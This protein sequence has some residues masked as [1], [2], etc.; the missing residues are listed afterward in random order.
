VSHRLPK[1]KFSAKFLILITLLCG[2]SASVLA[3]PELNISINNSEGWEKLESENLD[4]EDNL[5]LSENSSELFLESNNFDDSF[6]FVDSSNDSV[7]L[8][9]ES[10]VLKY[11]TKS[12]SVE[13]NYSEIDNVTGFD[14][15]NGRIF[16]V[17]ASG[18][19]SIINFESSLQNEFNLSS[20]EAS[21]VTGTGFNTVIVGF[22]AGNISKIGLDGGGRWNYSLSSGSPTDIDYFRNHTL[23]GTSEGELLKLNLDGDLSWIEQKNA[24]NINSISAGSRGVL[25]ASNKSVIKTNFTDGSEIWEYEGTGN[26]TGVDYST[27][28]TVAVSDSGGAVSINNSKGNEISSLEY[29]QGSTAVAVEDRTVFVAG[30]NG[31]Y[32]LNRRPTYFSKGSIEYGVESPSTVKWHGITAESNLDNQDIDIRLEDSNGTENSFD[33]TENFENSLNFSSQQ[34]NINISFTGNGIET[35]ALKSINLEGVA[36]DGL[37]NLTPEGNSSQ[38]PQANFSLSASSPLIENGSKAT[39]RSQEGVIQQQDNVS[40]NR[41]QVQW[42]YP[43]RGLNE[44]L[45][46]LNSPTLGAKSATRC[47]TVGNDTAI[48]CGE[49]WKEENNSISGVKVDDNSVILSNKSLDNGQTYYRNKGK[50]QKTLGIGKKVEWE[51]LTI[52]SDLNSG[53]V[54][55]N[56]SYFENLRFQPEV[57]QSFS[58][59]GGTETFDLNENYSYAEIALNLRT[60]SPLESPRIKDLFIKHGSAS[61]VEVSQKEVAPD[62]K[63][64]FRNKVFG[65][66]NPRFDIEFGD[67]DNSERRKVSHRYPNEVSK[68]SYSVNISNSIESLNKTAEVETTALNLK[69]EGRAQNPYVIE[70]CN[71]L[72]KIRLAPRKIYELDKDITC[73]GDTIKPIGHKFGSK[74][75]FDGRISGLGSYSIADIFLNASRGQNIGLFR[76]WNSSSSIDGLTIDT[77][78]KGAESNYELERAGGFAGKSAKDIE[79]D[80][81]QVKSNVNSNSEISVSSGLLF[82]YSDELKISNSEL[83]GNVTGGSPSGGITGNSSHLQVYSSNIDVDLENNAESRIGNM[84][85][86]FAGGL[87]GLSDHIKIQDVVVNGTVAGGDYIGGF[88]GFVGDDGSSSDNATFVGTLDAEG[89][90]YAGGGFGSISNTAVSDF[91]FRGEIESTYRGELYQPQNYYPTSMDEN[92]THLFVGTDS[93]C[94]EPEISKLRLFDSDLNIVDSLNISKD[95]VVR[96]VRKSEEGVFLVNGWGKKGNVTYVKTIDGELEEIWEYSNSE[97]GVH[98]V[99]PTG[100][101]VYAAAGNATFYNKDGR[102]TI[103]KLDNSNGEV[104]EFS[105]GD[106]WKIDSFRGMP[107]GVESDPAG[108][109]YV[110]TSVGHLIKFD[111]ADGSVIWNKSYSNKRISMVKFERGDLYSA[112]GG[113]PRMKEPIL[114]KSDKLTGEKLKDPSGDNW[115]YNAS[116]MV[117]DVEIVDGV[118]YTAEGGYHIE[119]YQV[120]KID[121]ENGED[122]SKFT[123]LESN[124]VGVASLNG[125]I[126]TASAFVEVREVIFGKSRLLGGLAGNIENSNISDLELTG[127]LE[128]EKNVGGVAGVSNNITVKNSIVNGHLAAERFTGSFVANSSGRLILRN[129]SS[130]MDMLASNGSAGGLIGVADSAK[131]F[132]SS[133]RGDITVEAVTGVVRN[134]GGLIGEL[135]CCGGELQINNSGTSGKISA[136][137]LGFQSGTFNVGGLVGKGAA[138][139]SNSYSSMKINTTPSFWAG[140]LIGRGSD[141]YIT[142]SRFTGK[143]LQGSAF[144]GGLAG[145]LNSTDVINSSSSA[146]II[147]NYE[148]DIGKVGGLIGKLNSSNGEKAV[149]MNSY[150]TGDTEAPKIE[151]IGGLLGEISG[152]EIVNSNATGN[153][154]ASEQAGGLVGRVEGDVNISDTF[155]S[156]DVAA[157][158]NGDAGGL[159]GVWEEGDCCKTNYLNNSY[160]LGDVSSIS[161]DNTGGLV[162]RVSGARVL[163]SFAKGDVKGEDDVGGLVGYLSGSASVERSFA[164]G[165]IRG[166][167][168]VGGLAGN[169]RGSISKSYARGDVVGKDDEIGGFVGSAVEQIEKSFATGN[170]EGSSQSQ[171]VGGFVG[172]ADADISKSFARGEVKGSE[173]VGGFVGYVSFDDMKEVYST[174]KVEGFQD[175]GGL[176]GSGDVDD[177]SESYWDAESS[178]IFSSAG[179]KPLS[180][181]EIKNR[182]NLS[183]FD[184]EKTWRI[185]SDV[186]DGYPV[187]RVFDNFSLGAQPKSGGIKIEIDPGKNFISFPISNGASYNVTKVLGNYSDRI[188]SVSTYRNGSWRFSRPWDKAFDSDFQKVRGGQ[189]YIVNSNSTE[190]F[191]IRFKPSKES[192]LK[193]GG[194]N[195]EPGGWRLIGNYGKERIASPGNAFGLYEDS[196]FQIVEHSNGHFKAS[197]TISAGKSYWVKVEEDVFYT[198]R[199]N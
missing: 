2:I 63:I 33:L 60:N 147:S 53:S 111:G 28:L 70:S 110:G 194:T 128:G 85:G 73:K 172:S 193:P 184:F 144:V 142:N 59:S 158:E 108:N 116:D 18:N 183:G 32:H 8:G 72:K 167:D 118:M 169:A 175:Y 96:R 71:D 181:N 122:L 10:S 17:T 25:S 197:D 13:W 100:N 171:E 162:G 87:S 132:N 114:W 150:S 115:S 88:A 145:R 196:K 47:I 40:A 31:F 199:L 7:F 135:N 86:K 191:E 129:V 105:D 51:N 155:A 77:S 164:T 42:N 157:N 156:G 161:N 123:D 138:N 83:S 134:F 176:A 192:G 44:W 21:S 185:D 186:N 55:I 39:F 20:R 90:K 3:A 16:A 48:S 26:Y 141:G 36:E 148:N 188:E 102:P 136:E 92:E 58:L 84:S 125:K 133:Y 94:S 30:K 6:S 38:R 170:V 121:P 113:G 160:A 41:S 14:V 124:A 75:D 101:Y 69:G 37:F 95:N 112:W 52:N 74:Q 1:G 56:I 29:S 151:K 22:R 89:Q 179:G 93:C 82:G 65:I 81:I 137:L 131:I 78:I 143:F 43:S 66:P 34:L 15:E 27:N 173:E 127:S 126:F 187:L 166:K 104:A 79:A 19:L 98:N 11:D 9:G 91:N 190:K 117:R 165:E 106:D 50:Y 80:S 174:G 64:S 68:Y 107:R 99:A 119:N 195:L 97:V 198:P 57:N 45:V 76:V 61:A 5:K 140:G 159:V 153:V 67:G 62:S 12:N 149:V 24:E 23:V 103:V 146:K 49:R 120:T 54:D 139:V 154:R 178:E 177:F 4:L 182:S 168:Y 189:G 152:A 180:T 109:V 35:P 46:K 163:K 130:S